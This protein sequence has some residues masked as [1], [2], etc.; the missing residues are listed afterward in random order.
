MAELTGSLAGVGLT[1][2]TH[3]LAE[4]GKSGDL[5]ISRGHWFG[6]VSLD[7]GRLSAAAFEHET[8]RAAL[9]LIVTG[10]ADGDFEFCEGPPTLATSNDPGPAGLQDVER[11][12]DE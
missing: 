5:L 11:I 1:A 12:A 9:E 3:F 10:L 6:Q 7:H 4:L 2:L 8:G